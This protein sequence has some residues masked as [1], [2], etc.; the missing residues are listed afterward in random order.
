MLRKIR[1]P[2]TKSQTLYYCIY[3]KCQKQAIHRNKMYNSGCQGREKEKWG[4]GSQL[5]TLFSSGVTK[6]FWDK[7]FLYNSVNIVK[8]TQLLTYKV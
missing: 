6:Y 4:G 1:N 5:G 8:T 7:W 2:V 3:I